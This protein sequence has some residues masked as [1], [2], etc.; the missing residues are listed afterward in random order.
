MLIKPKVEIEMGPAVSVVLPAEIHKSLSE[1]AEMSGMSKAELAADA[2]AD[3]VKYQIE[4][5]L[6]FQQWLASNGAAVPTLKRGA[7]AK[8]KSNVA[9]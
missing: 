3:M 8:A 6:A 9:E 1:L 5:N 2:V 4:K 7:K